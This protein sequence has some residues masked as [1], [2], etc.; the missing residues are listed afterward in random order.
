MA[1]KKAEPRWL[2]AARLANRSDTRVDWLVRALGRAGVMPRAE[3][4]GAVAAGRVAVNGEVIADPMTPV[5]AQSRVTV[6]GRPVELHSATRCLM[7][8]KPAGLVTAGVDPEGIGTVHAFLAE[9]LD[10]GLRGYE[11]LAIGRL[12]R[13]TTGLLLFTNDERLVAQVNA[14][15]THLPKTYLAEVEGDPAEPALEALRTGVQLSDG[16]TRPAKARRLGK[17]RVELVLTEGRHHQVKRMLKKVG[18]P[19]KTLHRARVGEVELD[20]PPGAVRELT[21]SELREGLKFE[22]RTSPG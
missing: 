3:A 5:D 18:H 20:L 16:P 9:R 2:Q 8:H 21:E 22:P 17:G 14:P 11:W 10:P 15:E 19:V 1:R 6:D 13:D 7:L 12:D 4:Q